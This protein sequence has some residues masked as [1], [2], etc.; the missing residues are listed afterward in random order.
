MNPAVL[1]DGRM[2]A[3][4]RIEAAIEYEDRNKLG[5]FAT[6]FS[7][8]S[9][10]VRLSVPMVEGDNIRFLDPAIGTGSFY[11]ALMN[12]VHNKATV[13]HAEG[14]E[15][16]PIF[17]ETASLLWK[18]TLI[19]IT[20]GDFTK[21]EPLRVHDRLANLIVCNP[22]YSR[23]HHLSSDEK[24]RLASEAYRITG[25]RPSGPSGL[26]CYFMLIAHKWLDAGGVGV[27]L[28]PSEFMDINFGKALREYLTTKV[29][30]IRIHQ[31]APE[32]VRF[33]DALVSSC[34]VWF[35]KESP[36]ID[37]EAFM[38]YGNDIENPSERSTIKI[39]E[40]RSKNK[41]RSMYEMVPGSEGLTLGDL[42]QI[43]R[44]IA[45]GDNRFFIMTEDE[46]KE[47][48]I[49]KENITPIM[50]SPRHLKTDLVEADEEGVPL[51]E[52]RLFLINTRQTLGELDRTDPSLKRYLEMGVEKG[53]S[54]GYLCS[55]RD[56]WYGQ[57]KREP[58]P[59]LISYMG[60]QRS[61]GSGTFRIIFNQSRATA[62]NAYLL[63]YPKTEL[64]NIIQR[65]P[66][67][68]KGIWNSM[69]KIPSEKFCANGRTYG[70]GLKKMEPRELSASSAQDLLDLL[71]P[72]VKT[73][74]ICQIRQS[75]KGKRQFKQKALLDLY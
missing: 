52:Q 7:L 40:L 6:P 35:I 36:S 14:Y 2:I 25:I 51:I 71:P 56:P 54:A 50:P 30:L 75:K 46:V 74:L 62:T 47:S 5:Q 65:Q 39:T 48:G 33:D 29:R 41:W 55:S 12:N 24:K 43:K 72:E 13:E 19:N 63:L 26:Y 15:I 34:V 28:I 61:G 37:D 17:G 20:I 60:R 8:A 11:S 68:M 3:Q 42:F 44:G 45:T 73:E 64:N 32:D 27:W 38:T 58:A 69:K 59:L 21:S 1:E 66:E 18:D 49:R 57:E 10:I 4:R 31:F 67:L 9:S 23:H 53:V 16:D 22:P 70:G